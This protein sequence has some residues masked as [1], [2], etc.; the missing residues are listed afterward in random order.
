MILYQLTKFQ[1]GSTNKFR[2]ILL[3]KYLMEF[4]R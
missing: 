3:R 2:E 1:A 4:V